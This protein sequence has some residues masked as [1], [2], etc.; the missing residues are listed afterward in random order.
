VLPL[1]NIIKI[2]R[3]D[4]AY[5]GFDDLEFFAKLAKIGVS[6]IEAV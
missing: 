2:N 1:C 5:L 6:K 4:Q 3:R